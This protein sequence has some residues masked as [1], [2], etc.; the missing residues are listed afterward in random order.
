MPKLAYPKD[1]TALGNAS[2]HMVV[3]APAAACRPATLRRVLEPETA[4]LV[5]SLAAEG[6]PGL[7][8]A[9]RTTRVQN[10]GKGPQRITLALLPDKVS[11]HNP[12]SRSALVHPLIRQLRLSATGKSGVLA[13]VDRG[14]H[15]LPVLLNAAR[16]L[17]GMSLRKGAKDNGTVNLL[18]VNRK[19][20]TISADKRLKE[21]LAASREAARL[22]DA[23]PSNMHPR[24]LCAEAKRM[25][26]GIPNVRISE[27]RGTALLE[28]GLGGIHGVGR[29]AVE[30]PRMLIAD[31]KPART[32]GPH[33]ALV[34]KGITYDTGGLHVKPRG[35]ME[36]MK[37]DMGGSA[38]VL[39]AFRTLA[40]T[41]HPGRVTLL[42]CAAENA[43]GPES[44][45]PDDVLTLHSGLT[46]EI[47]NTDAEGRL[48]L[49]DGVS[50]A[51]RILK[52]PF[53]LDAATLTG[54]Q[55]IATGRTHGAVVSNDE[56]LEKALVAAGAASGDPVHPLPF[57]PELYRKEFASPI[58]DMRNS[59]KDRA[60]AQSSC[61]AEFV[62]W[63][64]D[65]AEGVQWGHIDL[66]GPA[67]SGDCGTGYGV[68]LIA[69][70]VRS[71]AG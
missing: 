61:A 25:L 42:L 2:Q 70:T 37:A 64:L 14:E 44:Y 67:T 24:Q 15:A 36:G 5:A 8:G 58:A 62:H 6:G 18:A 20:E 46:V 1:P 63:H 55:L 68:A 71:L 60:N 21:V 16:G 31:Y 32:R 56:R 28:K 17:P 30:A 9:L 52:A 54:A 4:K 23:P 3:L 48:L 59:V 29:A 66:A 10:P 26:K 43:I 39:G 35:G 47:N 53:V 19:G 45:K 50:Y 57:A 34:G 40:A 65:G 49:A 13:I 38:A 11:R 69:E 7:R 51:A 22:V 27:I 41:K 33:V 12:A